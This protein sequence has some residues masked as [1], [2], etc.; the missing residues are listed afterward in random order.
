MLLLDIIT[1]TKDDFAGLK[2]TVESTSRLRNDSRVRQ[3]VI[4]SSSMENSEKVKELLLNENNTVY[5]WQEPAG[6]SSAFNL[7]IENSKAD[8][9]WFLNG[10]DAVN[11]ELNIN[12]FLYLLSNMRSDAAIFQVSNSQSGETARHPQMWALWPPLL[13]WIPHPCALTRRELYDKYGKFDVKLK[14]AMDYEFWVR[15]FARDVVVDLVSISVSIFDQTG[16][17]YSLNSITKAEVRK[18]IRR[19]FWLILK[20]WFSQA[21]IILKSIKVSLKYS[22]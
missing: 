11:P 22:K 13:S 4:D 14:T 6:I 5:L 15:C 9:L 8:W 18:V 10:G 16:I 7:G 1:I 17:S 19:Y 20:R 2:K 21:F 3:L 12:N